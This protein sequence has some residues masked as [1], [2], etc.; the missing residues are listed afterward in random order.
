LNVIYAPQ[1][2][3]NDAAISPEDLD[4][5]FV[6]PSSIPVSFI[7]SDYLENEIK[8]TELAEPVS[9]FQPESNLQ[10]LN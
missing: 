7:P 6:D 10:T 2:G 4:P 8:K 9:A 3:E 5:K 1:D